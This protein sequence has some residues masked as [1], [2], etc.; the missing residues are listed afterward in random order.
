VKLA[1]IPDDI[2]GYGHVKEAHLV[3]ARRKQVELLAQ[4]RNPAPLTQAAE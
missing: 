2:K 4:W 3:K 1:S